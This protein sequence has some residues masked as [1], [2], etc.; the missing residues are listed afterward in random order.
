MEYIE[1]AAKRIEEAL[2]HHPLVKEVHVTLDPGATDQ[3]HLLA[4]V[5]VDERHAPII[6]GRTRYKLPNS[7]AIVHQNKIETDIMYK[8]IFEYCA[9]LRHG[10][11]IRDGDCIFDVGANIGMFTL[12]VQQHFKE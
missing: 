4:Y 8:E 12:F 7:M 10:I 2:Q 5:V 3:Q 1:I 9:Y 6:G 11:T